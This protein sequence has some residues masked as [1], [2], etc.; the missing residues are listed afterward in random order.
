MF[1]FVVAPN[2]TMMR[3]DGCDVMMKMS[4]HASWTITF[5][6]SK[7][8]P[9]N[10]QQQHEQGIDEIRGQQGCHEHQKEEEKKILK[11]AVHYYHSIPRIGIHYWI[12]LTTQ[13]NRG[14]KLQYSSTLDSYFLETQSHCHPLYD[15]QKMRCDRLSTRVQLKARRNCRECTSAD[16]KAPN[17]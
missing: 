5:K 11:M 15:S 12:I 17:W 1:W 6:Q 8:P 14:F 2:W 3:R 4:C 13:L 9:T 7:A 16:N 10:Y